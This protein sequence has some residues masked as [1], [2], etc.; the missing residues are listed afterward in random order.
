MKEKILFFG[1]SGFVGIYFVRKL[2]ELGHK[3]VVYDLK[4][5]NNPLLKMKNV[6]LSAHVG[7]FSDASMARRPVRF[8]EEIARVFLGEMPINLVNSK[9]NEK[10][11]LRQ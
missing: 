9:V 10:L 3:V 7:H 5:P 4:K 6:V 2:L 8:G 1:G 11:Q